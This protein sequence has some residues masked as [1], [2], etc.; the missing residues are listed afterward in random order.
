MGLSA[1]ETICD[2]WT[3][4]LLDPDDC[5]ACGVVWSWAWWFPSR[6]PAN[7]GPLSI[8]RVC[9]TRYRRCRPPPLPSHPCPSVD[10]VLRDGDIVFTGPQASPAPGRAGGGPDLGAGSGGASHSPLPTLSPTALLEPAKVAFA[11][12]RFDDALDALTVFM[13]LLSPSDGPGPLC[14]ALTLRAGTHFGESGVTLARALWAKCLSSWLLLS[15]FLLSAVNRTST[16]ERI[17]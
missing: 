2:L 7:V 13:G 4:A 1:I 12:G 11:Q 16:N 9:H 5:G 15:G 17:S 3:V 6:Q 8:F 10:D 14:A